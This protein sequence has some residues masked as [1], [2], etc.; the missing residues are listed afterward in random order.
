MLW[1]VIRSFSSSFELLTGINIKMHL[2][3]CVKLQLVA[4]PLHSAFAVV[5]KASFKFLFWPLQVWKWNKPASKQ[6]PQNEIFYQI[7]FRSRKLSR[8]HH[9]SKNEQLTQCIVHG[10]LRGRPKHDRK[11]KSLRLCLVPGKY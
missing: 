7:N 1:E 11:K 4:I 8:W 10:M 5:L 2:C 6:R 9:N 3:A